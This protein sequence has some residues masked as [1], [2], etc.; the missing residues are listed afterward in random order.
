MSTLVQGWRKREGKTDEEEEESKRTRLSFVSSP[1]PDVRAEEEVVAAEW[2]ARAF[3]FAAENRSA[4]ARSCS[5][6]FSS[7]SSESSESE[8]LESESSL[9]EEGSEEDSTTADVGT[10]RG[11]ATTPRDRKV[12]ESVGV[13]SVSPVLAMVWKEI[14]PRR[15]KTCA[16]NATPL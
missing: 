12:A 7:C 14:N 4:C 9:E 2:R 13:I 6:S 5:S 15:L 1:S 10:S 8:L 3:A 11:L 16:T